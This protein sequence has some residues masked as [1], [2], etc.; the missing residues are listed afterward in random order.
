MGLKVSSQLP[1]VVL[2]HLQLLVLQPSLFSH[3]VISIMNILGYFVHILVL[4]STDSEIL[5]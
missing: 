5:H 3:H 2:V 1:F 4:H